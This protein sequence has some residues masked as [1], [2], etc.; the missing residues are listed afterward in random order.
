MVDFGM[1]SDEMYCNNNCCSLF[2]VH[3]SFDMTMSKIIRL[4]CLFTDVDCAIKCRKQENCFQISV[5]QS[6]KRHNRTV[7]LTGLTLHPR[8]SPKR[9]KGKNEAYSVLTQI[10]ASCNEGNTTWNHLHGNLQTPVGGKPNYVQ[11]Y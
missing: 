2:S 7:Q 4:P 1:Q 5:H 9:V 3:V 6:S 10:Q 8:R 11:G